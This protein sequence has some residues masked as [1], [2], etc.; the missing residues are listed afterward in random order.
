MA[1]SLLLPMSC[2]G[3][4]RKRTTR[5]GTILKKTESSLELLGRELD[6]LTDKSLR[7]TGKSSPLTRHRKRWPSL[8]ASSF[9]LPIRENTNVSKTPSVRIKSPFSFV[10]K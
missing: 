10:T 9:T 1:S 2:T 3:N 6:P 5:L 4:V 8:L 7:S